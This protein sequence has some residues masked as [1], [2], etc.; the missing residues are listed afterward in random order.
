MKKKT[1]TKTKAI[2]ARTKQTTK[3]TA[4][5]TKTKLKPMF[6]LQGTTACGETTVLRIDSTFQLSQ[7][8]ALEALRVATSRIENGIELGGV[9]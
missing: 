1:T 7:F 5:K 2:S 6:K 4:K 8:D 9:Q 3:T